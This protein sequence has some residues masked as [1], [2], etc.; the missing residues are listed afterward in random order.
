MEIEVEV[1][2]YIQGEGEEDEL[3]E[4]EYGYALHEYYYLIQQAI[5]DTLK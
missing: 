3:G 4:R 2:R 1:P 5:Q